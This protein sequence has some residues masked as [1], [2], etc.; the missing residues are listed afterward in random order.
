MATDALVRGYPGLAVACAVTVGAY[1]IDV[2]AG[3]PYSSVSVL[4][5]NP[6]YGIRFF[7]IG[8]E[9]EAIL[10]TLTLVGRR[11][12]A[13]RLARASSGGRRR[14]GSSPSR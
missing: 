11:V 3:S 6:A 9:L 2:V 12:L 14:P 5:P 1:A 7:G 4:G 10:T 8:N 13:R